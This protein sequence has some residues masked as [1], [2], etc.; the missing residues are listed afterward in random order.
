MLLFS[1]DIEK[2]NS[3][4]SKSLK[5]MVAPLDWGWGH[6]TRCIPI[7][8]MLLSR[9]HTILIAC[10]G[11]QK[12]IF[13]RE[14]PAL[15]YLDLPGYDIRYGNGR[16]STFL[17]IIF[18]IPKI[19][20]RINREKRWL[21][22][23]PGPEKPDILISDN[24]YGLASK[25]IFTV[26]I[27]HQLT[28]KTH[29]GGLFEKKL[30][31]AGYRY[32]QQFSRCWIPDCPRGES[33]AGDL[34]HPAVLPAVNTQYIGP[35]TRLIRYPTSGEILDLLIIISGP[36]PQRTLFEMLMLR[37]LE[38]FPGKAVLVRGLPEGSGGATETGNIRMH[39]HLPAA[40]LS[41]LV[42]NARRVLC[43]SGYSSVMD[44]LSLGKKTIMVPTPGQPEQEY[45][46]DYLF[47][48]KWIYVSRQKGFSLKK[49][50][51]DSEEFSYRIPDI[52]GMGLL[53][54]AIEDLEEA[55][56]NQGVPEGAAFG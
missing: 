11:A 29:F 40:E 16:W 30:Q 32:I 53:E 54:L 14:F 28:I 12:A 3:R 56:A 22:A 6:T 34:S 45:L 20:I 19:L 44:L 26:F 1:P 4:G 41:R 38:G 9:G 10:N 2:I 37:Q 42:G 39:N 47:R 25:T 50:M 49:A 36:E 35:L 51:A 21:E 48:K 52:G 27:T 15:H 23:F 8:N 43:R 5:I 55:M 13:S 33:M 46:A 7:I 24:R 18:Q 17:Q 31:G